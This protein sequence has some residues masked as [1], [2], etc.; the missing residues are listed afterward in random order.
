MKHN[1]RH[2]KDDAYNKIIS[3][4]LNKYQ[5]YKIII[6]SEGN[7]DDFKIKKNKRIKF[8]LNLEIRQTFHSLVCAKILIMAK[9]SFSY[10]AALINKNKVYYLPF[11]H[12]KLDHWI[13]MKIEYE[14]NMSQTLIL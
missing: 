6:F 4:L 3:Y 12:K 10:C 14:K 5:G 2:T 11:H 13:N 9:S 7:I 1:R 8:E